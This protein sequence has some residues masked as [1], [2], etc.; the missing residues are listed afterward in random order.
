MLG[1]AYRKVKGKVLSRSALCGEQG[2]TCQKAEQ[3]LTTGVQGTHCPPSL[4]SEKGSGGLAGEAAEQ[5][6]TV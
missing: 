2:A 6:V 3:H 4:S 5:E 1:T